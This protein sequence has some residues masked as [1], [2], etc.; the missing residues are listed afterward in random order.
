MRLLARMI[1]ER[2]GYR[3]IVAASAEEAEQTQ[4]KFAG[5]IRLLIT[6]VVLPGS[7]GPDLFRRLS[8]RDRS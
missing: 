5:S 2:A 1:L 6:D 4:L 7:S 3:V 8:M